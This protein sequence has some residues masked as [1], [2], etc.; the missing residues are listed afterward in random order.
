MD[1]KK[2]DFLFGVSTSAYQNEEDCKNSDWFRWE[3]LGKTNG[4]KG[5]ACLGYKDY[6]KDV[7][8]LKDLGVK[9]YRFS[10]EWSR[11]E[12]KEGEFDLKEIEHYRNVLLE[13]KKNKIIPF[14]TLFH[15]SLPLWF[16]D[17]G[18]FEKKENIKYFVRFVEKIV[19]EYKGLVKFWMTINEPVV[20][21][22]SSYLIGLHPPGEKS[23]FKCL[24]VYS[25][26]IDAQVSVYDSIKKIQENSE[27]GIVKQEAIFEP[28]HDSFFLKKVISLA[29]YFFNGRF[30]EKLPKDKFDFIGLDYYYRFRAKFKLFRTRKNSPVFLEVVV[31]EEADIAEHFG[32]EFYAKGLYDL[33]K[34]L[35]KFEKP[36][37]ITENGIGTDYDE[38]RIRFIQEHLGFVKKAI[39]EGVD[40]RGYFYWTL[41]D[42]FEWTF[43]YMSKF[44]L[45]TRDKKPKKS[46]YFYKKVCKKN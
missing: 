24:K 10:I 46:Y 41:F 32:F 28:F 3:K 21:A 40:V 34:G 39:E 2:K 18:G 1:L 9:A 17:K 43:G 15:F 45:L 8:I 44:G 6:K 5:N 30:L 29:R 38:K 22:Y 36:I 16:A 27:V 13:L 35:K 25:N 4:R 33:L 42:N 26:L 31:P 37:Y 7:R 12:P 23:L 11:I 14:V 20:Y 19:S